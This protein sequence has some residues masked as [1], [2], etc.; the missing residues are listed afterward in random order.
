LY[1]VALLVVV[2]MFRAAKETPRL[3]LNLPTA[4]QPGLPPHNK[5]PALPRTPRKKPNIRTESGFSKE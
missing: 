1:L 4:G 2:G 3:L 5:H